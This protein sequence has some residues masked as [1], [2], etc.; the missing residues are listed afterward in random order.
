M[1]IWN[2]WT[3]FATGLVIGCSFG[4]LLTALLTISSREDERQSEAARH[5]ANRLAVSAA[6][7]D[8]ADESTVCM[9]ERPEAKRA[10]LPYH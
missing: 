8:D 5:E 2:V 7:R 3:A 6:N 9:D 10:P 1:E 4:M